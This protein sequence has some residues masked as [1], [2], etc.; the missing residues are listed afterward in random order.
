MRVLDLDLDFFQEVALHN[1]Q[2]DRRPTAREVV[3]W[4]AESVSAFLE[5]QC[6]LSVSCTIPGHRVSTHDEVFDLWK[7]QIHETEIEAPFDV[8]HID[9]HADL[10]LGD[11]S[12][13]Y[14]T[15]ELVNLDQAGREN[16]KRGGR[17]GL[18][19][20]NYLAFA[21][22]CRW[23]RTLTYVYHAGVPGGAPD[24][25]HPCLFRNHDTS[26][27]FLELPRYAADSQAN[28][29]M[30]THPL[31]YEPAVPLTVVA[32]DNFETRE[33]FDS[34]CLSTSPRFTSVATEQ[35][36]GVVAEYVDF[37]YGG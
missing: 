19:E 31:S 10:G 1:V 23:L 9:A 30:D 6:G 7:R 36:I 3:P 16:P 28:V 22:A 24:D 33:A 26:V 37:G 21:V 12:W 20:G 2:G 18:S 13:V 8:V 11:A 25:L 34:A 4:A 14:I 15:A 29:T 35:L 5:R 17:D 32:G 27:G